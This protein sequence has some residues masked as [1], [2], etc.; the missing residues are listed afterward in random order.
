M[1]LSMFEPENT[2][3]V[4]AISVRQ[5]AANKI[6]AGEKTIEIRT[7]TTHYRGDLLIVSSA[8]PKI[9]PAGCALCIV[10][11]ADVRPMTKDDEVAACCS[12][13]P[14]YISWVLTDIRRIEPFPVKGRLGIYEIELPVISDQ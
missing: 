11:L 2:G 12:W 14:T 6:A 5:P 13:D 3:R 1:Q 4:K 10:R 7:W 8:S 9:E